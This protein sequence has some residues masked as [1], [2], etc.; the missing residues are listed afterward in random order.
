MNHSLVSWARPLLTQALEDGNYDTLADTRL[1]KNYNN[2]EMAS[3][4]ACAAS[5]IRHSTWRRPRMSQVVRALEGDV[6]LSEVSEGIRPG[7]STIDDSQHLK[8]MNKLLLRLLSQENS[9]NW[10]S[11]NSS[12][13]GIYPSG[14]CIDSRIRHEKIER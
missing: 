12:E 5:C 6:S 2:E 9:I 13:Y 11:D 8:H 14:S 3:M 1:Q 4:V 7:H 10:S